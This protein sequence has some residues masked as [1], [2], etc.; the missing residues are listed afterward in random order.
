MKK[1]LK[2]LLLM[3]GVGLLTAGCFGT[4]VEEDEVN[5]D[6]R[7]PDDDKSGWTFVVEIPEDADEN[8]F[9]IVLDEHDLTIDWG[10]GT[11]EEIPQ[12][13][14][15]VEYV[16]DE[17]GV[18]EVTL[19]GTVKALSFCS[20]AVGDHLIS[21]FI[22][23]CNVRLDTEVYETKRTTPERLKDVI[24]PIPASLGLER[25]TNMFAFIDVESF[26]AE[27]FF[28]EASSGVYDMSGMFM[29]AANFNQ[30]LNNW[31]VSQVGLS[32]DPLVNDM[33][34]MFYGA[35]SFNGDITGWDVS[36]VT[37]MHAM[38]AGAES[39]NQDIGDW[40]VS[41]LQHM[42]SMFANARSFN[43]DIGGWDVSNAYMIWLFYYAT[44]FNQDLSSWCVEHIDEKPEGFDK[45]ATAWIL[46]RPVWGTCP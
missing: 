37:N 38:F 33:Y 18:Y 29:N 42:I 9:L 34:G 12:D 10:D 43:Q 40:D 25:S 41:S 5:G 15:Y 46:P 22:R 3:L 19:D 23:D 8:N 31:D 27:N 6:V 44:S 17:A 26:T 11:K 24:S 1:E 13:L 7:K 39:F 16:Y 14:S 4:E 36:N 21:D 32:S 30:D 2:T 45:N 35:S 28:D 20:F